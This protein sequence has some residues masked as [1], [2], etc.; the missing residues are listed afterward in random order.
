MS[1]PARLLSIIAIAVLAISALIIQGEA[2][3]D[4]FHEGAPVVWPFV[5]AD[6][7]GGEFG[8]YGPEIYAPDQTYLQ[9]YLYGGPPAA[10]YAAANREPIVH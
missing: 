8:A 2:H 10:P 1:T 7:Y 5:L 3:G 4:G 9:T 6:L